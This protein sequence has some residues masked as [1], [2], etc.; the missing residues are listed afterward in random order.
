MLQ[1]A[2]LC[3]FGCSLCD[4]YELIAEKALATPP[5]TEQLMEL[6]A[7]IEKV[8]VQDVLV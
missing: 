5:N 4:E 8:R 6:K 3:D 1:Y 7:F 2:I